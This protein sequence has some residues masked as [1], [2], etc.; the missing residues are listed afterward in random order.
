[1]HTVFEAVAYAR[2]HHGGGSARLEGPR[3]EALRPKARGGVFGKGQ[4]GPSPPVM[5]MGSTVSSPSGLWGKASAA[6]RPSHILS[7]LDGV[8]C[9]IPGAFCTRKLY[10]V[11]RGKGSVTLLKAMWNSNCDSTLHQVQLANTKTRHLY[12]IIFCFV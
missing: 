3:C 11:Q 12:I 4:P 2:F 5:G 8:S 6:Q 9:C 1:M 7:A 10:G